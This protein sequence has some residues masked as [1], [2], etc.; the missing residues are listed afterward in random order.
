MKKKLVAKIL[1]VAVVA[2]LSLGLVAC[3]NEET[4]GGNSAAGE[5]GKTESDISVGIVV[6]TASNPHFKDIAY[7]AALAGKDLGVEVSVDNTNAESEIEAQIT[8][9][10]NMISAGVDALILTANDSA[11]MTVAVESAYNNGVEF[12]TVDTL[13]DN[14][15][16]DKQYDYMPTYLGVDHTVMAYNMACQIFESMGGE[17]NVVILRGVDAAS[18]S[19]ERTAGFKK[20]VDEYEGITLVAENTGEY[21]QAKGQQVMADILQKTKDID[22]VLCC[23]DMMALGAIAACEENNV[24][25]GEGGTLIAGIDGG[26]LALQAIESG[27]MCAT[28][29]DWSMLQGYYAVERAVALVKG[30]EVPVFTY[31]PDTIITA[32][33]V[34]EF[35]PHAEELEQWSMGAELTNVSDAM[36]DFLDAGKD[37]GTVDVE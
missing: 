15:W 1:S 25:V 19:N 9:C 31:T 16:G 26:L 2:A 11:G 6:K 18:S 3:G 4:P 35:L 33:N 20:A 10:E 12:V 14:V 23:N 34:A 32:E 13:I 24:T 7:G 17:G 8:K 36:Y 28:A 27:K 21:D 37:L 29:Y 30:E 22:V 5:T